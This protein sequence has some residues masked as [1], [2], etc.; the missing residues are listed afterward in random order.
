MVFWLMLA[1]VCFALILVPLV[2]AGTSSRQALWTRQRSAERTIEAHRIARWVA[3][4]EWKDLEALPAALGGPP[5]APF[6]AGIAAALELPDGEVAIGGDAL[7][8]ATVSLALERDIGGYRR[9]HRVLVELAVPA[10]A[11]TRRAADAP[12]AVKVAR[13]VY[14][15]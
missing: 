6:A 8:D 12:T 1:L 13:L 15:Q 3:A 9:L 2:Q 10:P 4:H 14:V 11:G 5:P 7:A